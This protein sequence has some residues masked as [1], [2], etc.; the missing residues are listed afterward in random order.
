MKW[1]RNLVV[2]IVVT[3]WLP[4]CASHKAYLGHAATDLSA[5][6]VGQDRAEVDRRL[7]AQDRTE[8]S[9][10]GSTV[11]YVYDRG[12]VGTLE[13][14]SAAEK[15]GWAPILAWGEMVSLGLAGWM[16]ACATPCQ[17]GWLK[18]DYDLADQLTD[19]SEEFLPADHPGVA[20]CAG[21][22]VRGEI[23]VCAGVRERVRP[24]SLDLESI[25]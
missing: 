25:P 12:Y 11:W 9:E 5:L 16:T 7:G 3:L 2:W 4:A 17:K 21:S 15:V 18:V 19:A 1:C 10:E 8:S 24:S 6:K 23:A 22:A 13:D 20:E 14:K